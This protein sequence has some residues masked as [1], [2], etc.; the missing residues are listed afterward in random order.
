MEADRAPTARTG[1]DNLI[2]TARSSS[3]ASREV[4]IGHGPWKG[5]A[6]QAPWKEAMVEHAL[7]PNRQRWWPTGP[8]NPRTLFPMFPVDSNRGGGDTTEMMNLS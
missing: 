7:V 3:C 8:P 5:V 4:V 1:T 2:C 6:E